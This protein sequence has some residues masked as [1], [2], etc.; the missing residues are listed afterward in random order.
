MQNGPESVAVEI[1]FLDGD[2][3]ISLVD[4]S[5]EWAVCAQ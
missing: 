1:I 2:I 4:L 5:I 3:A